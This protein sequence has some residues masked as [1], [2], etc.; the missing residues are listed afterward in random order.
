VLI[1]F[2]PAKDKLNRA[3]HGLSLAFARQLI[4]GEALVWVDSRYE[5]DEIRMIGLVP[6]GNTLYYVAFVDRDQVRRVI[7][8]RYAERKEIRHYAKN[9]P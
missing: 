2:D 4:W 1:D 6:E 5:Y 9:Y 3:Q 8:L 7:S